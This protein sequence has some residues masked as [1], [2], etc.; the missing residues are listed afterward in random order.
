[1]ALSHPAQHEESTS[2]IELLE[3]GEQSLS[4]F[5]H[6][7]FARD[8]AITVYVWR[9]RR[10][11]KVVL[12][13]DGQRIGYVHSRLPVDMMLRRND[14]TGACNDHKRQTQSPAAES[15]SRSNC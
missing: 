3:D 12:H 2:D 9:Q 15:A 4:V 13:I 8:P 5:D 7:R 14:A 1:M 11:V 10:N 6:A